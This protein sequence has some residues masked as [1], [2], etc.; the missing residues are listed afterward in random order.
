[1]RDRHGIALCDDAVALAALRPGV[2]DEVGRRLS[3]KPLPPAAH[4]ALLDEL[5]A[6]LDAEPALKSHVTLQYGPNGVQWCSTALLETIAAGS[7][8]SGR[9]VHMHLLETKY[10]REWADH[11]FPLG[12]R[13]LPRRPGPAEPAPDAGAL[14]LG[15]AGGAG[16]AGRAWRHHRGQ[17]QQQPGHQVGHR[18]GGGDA[19]P[20]LPRG[21]GPGRPGLRRGR[22]RPARDAPGLRPAPRLGL[23]RGHEPQR[24]VALRVRARTPQRQRRARGPDHRRS[25]RP[26]GHPPI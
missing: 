21:H 24:A 15:A 18:A 20:G 10:Q 7:A 11:T 14:H 6:R 2:R 1:M 25:H 16:A 22:R 12:H 23:R 4:L 9:P 19:A 8:Q 26:Q 5:A 3:V 13:A 17:H